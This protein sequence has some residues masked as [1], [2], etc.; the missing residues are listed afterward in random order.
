MSAVD[1]K[2]VASRVEKESGAVRALQA[3]IGKV[4]VGHTEQ[5]NGE[6]LDLG[7]LVCLDTACR[8][9]GWL[10]LWD[11][12]TGQTWQAS[13]WGVL[14]ESSHSGEFDHLQRAKELLVVGDAPPAT[15]R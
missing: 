2:E 8:S 7:H 13:K 11:A 1:I 9:Y 12:A 6:I 15:K 5:K 14:R 4:I 3:E 10:T